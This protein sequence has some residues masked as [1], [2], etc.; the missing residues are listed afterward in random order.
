MSKFNLNDIN[1]IARLWDLDTSNTIVI[2][3]DC[4]FISQAKIPNY[5]VTSSKELNKITLTENHTL[6]VSTDA[7][8]I[9]PTGQIPVICFNK[10]KDKNKNDQSFYIIT[11]K[12][13]SI[14]WMIPTEVIHPF[15]LNFYNS[16]TLLSKVYKIVFEIIYLTKLQR[17]FFDRVTVICGNTLKKYVPESL[18]YDSITLFTGTAGEN[19][20][21]ILC[22]IQNKK[23]VHFVKIAVNQSSGKNVQNEKNILKSLSL[24]EFKTFE[25]PEISDSIQANTIIISNIKPDKIIKESSYGVKHTRVISELAKSYSRKQLI[26]NLTIYKEIITYIETLKKAEFSDNGLDNKTVMRSV[27][28]IED[29]IASIKPDLHLTTSISHGD[30]TPWNM[31]VGLE[32]LHIYDWELA[33][34]DVPILFDYFHFVYQSNILSGNNNIDTITQTLL[35]TSKCHEMADLVASLNIN[36]DLVHALYLCHTVSYY[37]SL[38]TK[39]IP[40]HQQAHWLLATW[41]LALGR[42]NIPAEGQYDT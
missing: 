28:R 32:K 23:P 38:Y 36:Y 30:F 3:P 24:R 11:N 19:R 22:L 33:R 41:D 35:E 6:I 5:E 29:I 34:E 15:F 18:S 14:R 27:S 39:Q 42:V 26:G 20:K 7:K 31:F 25:H 2:D 4:L 17:L 9:Y 37:L 13:H 10:T 8:E 1:T 21:I 16:P 12:D 40:L